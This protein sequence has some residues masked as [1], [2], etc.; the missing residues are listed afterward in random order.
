VWCGCVVWV[1]GVGVWCGCVVWVC[2][3]F[4]A[5]TLICPHTRTRTH[6]VTHTYTHTLSHT[7]MCLSHTHIVIHTH[8]DTHIYTH[9]IH[10]RAEAGASS[11][12]QLRV[13]ITVQEVRKQS[14]CKQHKDAAITSLTDQD[15]G[16]GHC[17][18]YARVNHSACSASGVVHKNENVI[19]SFRCIVKSCSSD[20]G[21]QAVKKG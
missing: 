7:H 5:L 17:G 4:I 13:Q 10:V 1:C 15:G 21:D 2:W 19:D 6:I 12:Y 20:N 14:D 11:R 9:T 8:C 3:Q 18:H 16:C